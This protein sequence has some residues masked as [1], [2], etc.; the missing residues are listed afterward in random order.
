MTQVRQGHRFTDSVPGRQ[1][2]CGRIRELINTFVGNGVDSGTA[3]SY[4]ARIRMR[5]PAA[6][7]PASRLP[8]DLGQPL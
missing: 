3:G 7:D 6:R 1:C 5:G 4:Q 8:S 2:D